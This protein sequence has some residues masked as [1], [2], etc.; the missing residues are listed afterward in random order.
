MP[1]PDYQSIMLPLLKYAS[2]GREHSLHD[3]IEALAAEFRLTGE[4]RRV[5]LPSGQQAAFDNRVGW[6]RTYLKAAGLLESTRRGYF[7]LTSRGEDVLRQNPEVINDRFLRQ[8]AEFKEFMAPRKEQTKTPETHAMRT[9]IEEIEAAYQ[10]VTDDL[11]KELLS[12]ITKLSPTFFESLVVDL[13][14]RMG[15]GGTR[16]EAGQKLGGS[17]DDGVD[18]V[19]KQD[20]LGLDAVYIQAKRWDGPVGRPEIQKFAGALQGNRARKGVFITTSSFSDE[21][22]EYVTRIEAKI[23]LI[24]GSTLAELMIEHNVGVEP[25]RAYEVKRMDLEYFTE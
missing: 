9:P 8:F 25:V 4:E 20:R 5:L 6:A 21:A 14:V 22:K 12:A 15:Y 7:R 2:D 13:L 18:G 11:G 10:K 1:I 24:D 17:H 3:T 19:I 23:V 16:A